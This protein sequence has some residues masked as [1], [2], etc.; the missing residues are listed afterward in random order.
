MLNTLNFIFIVKIIIYMLHIEMLGT[1]VKY[2]FFGN[3]LIYR[4]LKLSSEAGTRFALH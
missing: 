4:L 1:L 2:L 3:I